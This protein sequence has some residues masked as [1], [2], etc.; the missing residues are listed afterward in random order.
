MKE[1]DILGKF[2]GRPLSDEPPP[3]SDEDYLLP[4][5]LLEVTDVMAHAPENG[6]NAIVGLK[7]RHEKAFPEE[8]NR[9]D[10]FER[11]LDILKRAFQF[12]SFRP[13]QENVCEAI[14]QGHDVLLVMPTGSGK[15]LCYQL[16][17]IA[18][19]GTTLV[20]S[21]LIA[22]MEDQTKSLKGFGFKAERIH[23]GQTRLKAREVCKAYIE[24]SL[25]FLFV[26]PERLA[27]PGFLKMIERHKP[28]LIAID[29]AHCISQWGH[30]FR[31]DYRL[32]G[33]RL[34]AFR[35]ASVIA[36][37]ATAT[38]RVQ[39]DIIRQLGMD[40]AQMHIHGFR[41]E[42]IAIEL[43]ELLPSERSTLVAEVLQREEW[44]P[45]IIY[46]PTRQKTED[47]ALQ[48]RRILPVASYHAG[49]LPEV[50]DKVQAAF[51]SG[52]L[53][54]IVATIAFGMGINKPDI[55]T[56][57]HTAM[58]GSLEGY[59]QEIGRAGRDGKRSRAILLH[60]YGDRRVHQFFHEKSYPHENILERIYDVITEHKQASDTIRHELG[61]DQEEFDRALEKLWI[62]GGALV[63]HND[64]VRRGPSNWKMTYRNQR[65]HRLHQIDE[66][67][68][69]ANSFSCRMLYL[70]RHFGDR[71]DDGRH[72]GL[73]DFCAPG[74]GEASLSRRPNKK[75]AKIIS[76]VLSTLRSAQSLGT[77]RLYSHTCPGATLSRSDFESLMRS[78]VKANLI[79]LREESFEKAGKTIYYK[80]A[81]LT[82]VGLAFDHHDIQSMAIINQGGFQK[83]QDKSQRQSRTKGHREVVKRSRKNDSKNPELYARLKK[84]RLDR[85]KKKRLPAFR[86]FT[87]RVLNNLASELPASDDELLM[88]Q[89]VGPYFVER[90]GKDIIKI[91]KAYLSEKT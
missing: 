57:I 35:S 22:L 75:E 71:E 84:W 62:H 76:D 19:G 40:G 69:F 50:R 65:D 10:I 42:N 36:M 90:Y 16:P 52:E 48:L 14:M 2:K 8:R 49:L 89:G 29:E 46:A 53:D 41:R 43:I 13:Y 1:P 38:P 24:G 37:T 21:P 79:T 66:I 26:A 12:E 59:Y 64:M 3:P 15:S 7:Q 91:V 78:L 83:K 85:A 25:D 28:V 6:E 88:V 82:E 34:P 27:V 80:R 23:S 77:G 58:P 87:N 5:P 67:S 44:R 74:N 55:R 31:P 73:C 51:F 70:V 81:A 9:G 45:A 60:S 86:I 17:G 20:V 18:L 63:D 47:L 30:D 4:D 32:L 61:M 72:C 54:A 11:P 39:K 56:V 33:E 68:R